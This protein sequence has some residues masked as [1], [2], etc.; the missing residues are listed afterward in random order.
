MVN[1]KPIH[2]TNF[3]NDFRPYELWSP[4]VVFHHSE[5]SLGGRL[6]RNRYFNKTIETTYLVEL[7]DAY[8]LLNILRGHTTGSMSLGEI[9]QGLQKRI[10]HCVAAHAKMP[11]PNSMH[12]VNVIFVAM[13]RHPRLVVYNTFMD[14]RGRLRRCTQCSQ[15]T[16]PCPWP[17]LR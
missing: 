13:V 2:F 15:L 17:I 8:V 10:Q 11:R 4:V 16:A 14:S 6:Y 5:R 12:R 9:E 3:T 7:A 1:I